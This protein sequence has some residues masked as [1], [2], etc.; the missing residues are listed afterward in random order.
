MPKKPDVLRLFAGESL[1]PPD[2]AYY[3]GIEPN[4]ARQ[5]ILRLKRQGLIFPH[6]TFAGGQAYSLTSKGETRIS[7]LADKEKRE[8]ERKQ[9]EAIEQRKQ[10]GMYL[11]EVVAE[12]LPKEIERRIRSEFNITSVERLGSKR[13]NEIELPQKIREETGFSKLNGERMLAHRQLPFDVWIRVLENA[14]K[15]TL[16]PQ[17]FPKPAAVPEHLSFQ[18]VLIISTLV[19]QKTGKFFVTKDGKILHDTAKGYLSMEAAVF[20]AANRRER[21]RRGWS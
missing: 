17:H 18:E 6:P 15:P 11:H 10:S 20:L 13:L 16:K 14:S 7:Y 19:R 2:L 5:I 1:A 9:R 3:L 8:A 12:G 4:Y 21:R